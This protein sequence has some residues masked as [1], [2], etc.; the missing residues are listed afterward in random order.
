MIENP[1]HAIMNPSSIAVVGASNNVSKMGT[2]Q[3][4]NIIY[5]G[6]AGD[7][8]PV[9]PTEKEIFGRK[10]YGA[11]ADLPRAPDLALLV[12][13][14]RIIPE[15]LEAFGRIGTRHAIIVTAGFRETGEQGV[16]LEEKINAIAERYGMRFVGPNCMGIINTRRRL[17]ISVLPVDMPDGVL[18][19]AS[20]SGTYITQTMPYLH[21]QGIAVSKAVSVGNEA[22][23]D[24]V[25]CL[26]FLGE[27]VDTRAICL[28]IEGIRRADR[29]LDAARRI[30]RSKPI[31]AQ[32]VGG[33]RA[34]ARSGAS[35]TGSMS[36]PDYVYDGL[37]EQAG[38]IRVDTI[39]EVYKIG[40]TLATQP[41][42][43]GNRAG[44]L[45]HSGGPGSAMSDVSD[46]HG[47]SIPAFSETLRQH[48]SSM[49]PGHAAT[50]NPV[51]LT[52]I[53]DPRPLTEEM[54]R[55]LFESGEIDGLMIHGIM[56]TDFSSC[57]YPIMEKVLDVSREDFV[58][59]SEVNLD[60]L[61]R[62]PAQ[63]GIPL[64]VS[65]FAADGDHARQELLRH[66]IPHF[67]APEKAAR[68]MAALCRHYQIRGRKI[69]TPPSP[70]EKPPEAETCMSAIR[71]SGA[72][73][74]T[75]K[76]L[77][78]AYG[79]PVTRE[80]RVLTLAEA[81]AAAG[82]IGYPAALK[83]CSPD[84]LHKTE[85][86]M[87]FLDIEDEKALAE[88]FAAI[89]EKNAGAPLLVSEMLRGKREFMAGVTDFP[90]FPPCV[91][92]GLGGILTEAIR[93][94]AIRLTPLGREDAGELLQAISAADMLGP[95]RGMPAVDLA[96]MTEILV[97]LSRLAQDFPEIKEID[98]NP[99]MVDD[100]G[101]P[102]VADAL[103]VLH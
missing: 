39:E 14:T 78:K 89:R 84:I 18:G 19:I 96:A 54:P 62:L 4:L 92:F 73:E 47:V 99:V 95:Y 72:D 15:V 67:D 101:Q 75:A 87:V 68:A 76:A 8:F 28:Y 37:F 23:I 82:R 56:D 32:Y 42:M 58:K 100:G 66:R 27:D 98:L 48:L 81:R 69:H 63:Y 24:L 36:G 80:K 60:A 86:G 3:L 40:W 85:Q 52:F 22:S 91:L 102:K 29:F 43:K 88:A 45:T 59:N 74:F 65:S 70:P 26:E 30:S 31:V 49:L 10:A 55:I 12:A 46:R 25:D 64:V 51:D 61:S 103:F 5:G 1:L 79:I 93:D 6:F 34:G 77:L 17:N 21:R 94:V 2:I 33:T 83:V 20:Q 53:P 11:V 97:N 50:G 57:M 38:V 9:H 7:I 16:A 44:I 90:G 13:P 71:T 35:H 41:P